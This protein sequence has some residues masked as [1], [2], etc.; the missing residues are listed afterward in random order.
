MGE[1]SS[2]DANQ[3]LV[4]PILDLTPDDKVKI[5]SV[6]EALDAFEVPRFAPNTGDSLSIAGRI[7]VVLD[8]NAKLQEK[9][10]NLEKLPV[11]VSE[12]ERLNV[13]RALLSR[14]FKFL[15]AFDSTA[16]L[17]QD[18]KLFMDQI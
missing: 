4:N 18:I 17:R 7:G 11:S 12:G 15:L 3:E 9:I 5:D 14:S 2:R 13:A 16:E 8:A 1:N 6:H 10:T